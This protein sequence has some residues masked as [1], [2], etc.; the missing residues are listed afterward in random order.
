M[1]GHTCHALLCRTMV[2]P[3]LHMCGRHWRMV[4]KPLQRQLWAEYRPGQEQDMQ[5][6][7]AYLRA[8]AACVEAVARVEGHH[9]DAIHAE[10]E[11]Y[12]TWANVLEA[13]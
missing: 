10:V 3:R 2:P 1:S 9:E 12:E 8:A 4:P 11:I 7:A 6:T 13:S 5:P